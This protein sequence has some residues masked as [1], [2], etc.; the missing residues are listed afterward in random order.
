VIVLK[1]TELEDAGTDLDEAVAGAVA[2][3]LRLVDRLTAKVTDA[4]DV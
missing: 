1:S 3:G 2:E 4:L